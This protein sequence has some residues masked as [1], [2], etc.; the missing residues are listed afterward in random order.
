MYR[1]GIIGCGFIGVEA[2]D[3]HALAYHENPDISLRMFC[4]IDISKAYATREKYPYV[5]NVIDD[6]MS[7]FK[8]STKPQ[9]DI[10]SVCTPPETHRQIV[11]DIAPYVKA[12]YCEKPIALT[13]E[14]ADKMIE[15]CN[16]N[17]VF[18]QVNH[19][20][21]FMKPVFRFSR[22][23]LNTGTHMFALLLKL[24]IHPSSVD[25]QCIETDEPIFEFDC[26]HN[27]ERMILAG[28]KYL[29]ECLD[30][31]LHTVCNGWVARQA[32]KWALEYKEQYERNK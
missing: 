18:L 27:K 10:V 25:I 4:D 28:L 30:V 20:R 24:G 13:L 17:A 23:W 16:R 14:D 3:N 6:Y 31:P 22:G 1:A 8:M 15:V 12:I 21:N 26:T 9:L 5:G 19:Q 11:C 2:P 32:L 7:F 29:I